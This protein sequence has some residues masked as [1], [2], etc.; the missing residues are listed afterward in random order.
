MTERCGEIDLNLDGEEGDKRVENVPTFRYLGLPLDQTDD[1]WP[2]VQ[3]NI[4]RSRLVWG[5]LGTLLRQEGEDTEVSE[6]FYRAVM[7]AILLYGSETW[8][9]LAS[10][11]KRIEATHTEFL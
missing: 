9:L 11:A 5:R 3:G 6:S 10:M 7:Q 4:M 8:V 1:Y 2:A